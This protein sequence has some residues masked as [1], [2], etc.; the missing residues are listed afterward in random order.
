M[1]PFLQEPVAPAHE[2][3]L[4]L[5]QSLQSLPDCPDSSVLTLSVELSI[6][7]LHGHRIR[8]DIAC[9]YPAGGHCD[10]VLVS[11]LYTTPFPPKG[12]SRFS[13]DLLQHALGGV[14]RFPGFE[15]PPADPKGRLA[16][17]M[18]RQL[19]TSVG[20]LETKLTHSR[21]PEE[22]ADRT[23]DNVGL[24]LEN[25]E[26]PFCNGAPQIV[27]SRVLLTND[28]TIRVA[29]EAIRK[30]ASVIVTYRTSPLALC[31]SWRD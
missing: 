21:Y 18:S 22:L 27:P 9:L 3:C 29:Q 20:C 5:L 6:Q 30:Q 28:L 16:P 25:T 7:A 26:P 11:H 19:P 17:P 10:E 1:T 14:Q 12:I 24:L 8:H 2:L 31:R 13:R 4:C 23:W 15:R